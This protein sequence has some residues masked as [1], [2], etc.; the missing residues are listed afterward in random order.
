MAYLI[1][2]VFPTGIYSHVLCK[3]ERLFPNK[4]NLQGAS[5][6]LTLNFVDFPAEQSTLRNIVRLKFEK[7]WEDQ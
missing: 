5:D 7:S 1:T 6:E 3:C 4:E 2:D